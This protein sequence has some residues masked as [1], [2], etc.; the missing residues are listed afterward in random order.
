MCCILCLP[1]NGCQGLE[2]M[3][4]IAFVIGLHMGVAGA[5]LATILSQALSAVL[6]RKSTR[7]NSS[8]IL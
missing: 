1:C 4:D 7:L 6:D 2:Y 5:A 3:L 8:H